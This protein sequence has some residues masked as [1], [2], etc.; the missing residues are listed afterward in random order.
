MNINKNSKR[1]LIL[2]ALL[3][4]GAMALFLASGCNARANSVTSVSIDFPHGATRLLVKRDGR[5]YLFYGELPQHQE[6]EPGTFD[7]DDLF[8]DLQGKLN[9]VLPAE[10][11]P[12]G[13][14]VGMV[15]FRFQ[16][17]SQKDYLIY[18]ADFAKSLF[19]MARANI[20]P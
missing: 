16:D 4:L 11:R 18:D 14:A 15:Q 12:L 13:A 7:I 20:L 1:Q 10:N 17:G 2:R 5:A 19:A 8:I 9:P 3:L 6:I